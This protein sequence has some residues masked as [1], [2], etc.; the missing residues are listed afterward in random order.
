MTKEIW[1]DM[2]GTIADLYGVEDWLS[3]LRNYDPTPYKVAKPLLHMASLAR[4]LNALQRKGYTIGV[5]SW[6]S[7]VSTPEYDEAVAAAKINWLRT[8]LKS[9]KFDHIDILPYGTPKQD[10]RNGILFDDNEE[11]RE[12]W[13]DIAFTENN[14]MEVL[15]ALA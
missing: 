7:K 6:V 14:I 5:V 1:F 10:G 8:H 9:V 3:M 12:D 2:D 13:A 11:I 4:K 15:K